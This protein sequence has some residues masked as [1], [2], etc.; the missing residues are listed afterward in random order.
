M[1]YF[2]VNQIFFKMAR[3]NK[4]PYL[5]STYMGYHTKIIEDLHD[6]YKC[7]NYSTKQEII[8]QKELL[9]FVKPEIV[10]E[11]EHSF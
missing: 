9:Q 4:L 10:K 2:A 5:Q 7:Y 8:I 6:K 1:L 3:E 11:W